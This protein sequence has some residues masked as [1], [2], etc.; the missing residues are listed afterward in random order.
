MEKELMGGSWY[1]FLQ[2]LLEKHTPEI[3]QKLKA[4]EG[5]V[6]PHDQTLIY[7][8]FNQ[9]ELEDLK[10]IVIMQDPYHTPL[11]ANGLIKIY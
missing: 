4:V 10:G 11:V 6:Y 3:Y 8:C 5:E 7:N 2:P 1:R 9:F